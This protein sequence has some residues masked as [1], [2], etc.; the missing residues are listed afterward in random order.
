[1][2]KKICLFSLVII[3][4]ISCTNDKE[5]D[6]VDV[7]CEDIFTYN[8]C[9]KA[10]IDNNCIV[11]HNSGANPVAPFPLETYDQVKDKAQNGQLLNRI[12][13]PDG[14]AAIMPQTGKMPQAN[15]DVIV[16]WANEGFIE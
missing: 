16:A 1:M 11:C 13:L 10:I 9:V 12:Q 14:D 5:G 8:D 15:I 4:F 6:L 7:L 2:I 3:S